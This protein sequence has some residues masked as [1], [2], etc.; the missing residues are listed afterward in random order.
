MKAELKIVTPKMAEEMLR[1]N[2]NN[3]KV[4][5]RHVSSLKKQMKE[6]KWLITGEAI[7][8]DK[9]GN[10]LDG[11]HRLTAIVQSECPI[12]IMVISDLDPEIFT[13]IDTGRTRTAGD[14]LHIN[15]AENSALVASVI[16]TVINL[17]KGVIT[18]KNS[19]PNRDILFFLEQN[20]VK[21]KDAYSEKSITGKILTKSTSISLFYLLSEL[22]REQAKVFMSKLESGLD[23]AAGSPIYVLRQRLILNNSS[24]AK[25]SSV[26]KIALVIKAWNLF[27]QDKECKTIRYDRSE[28][29]FPR[30]I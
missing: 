25:L 3:R 1:K 17:K 14:V 24:K 30:P 21:I 20:E 15:G 16:K 9:F 18:G 26:D 4:N 2:H 28:L 12:N 8:L 23:L 11:Q 7:K 5:Q 10:V 19:V 29:S 22:N 6:G 13:V 27:R